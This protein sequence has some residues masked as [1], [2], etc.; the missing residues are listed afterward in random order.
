VTAELWKS[1]E[2]PAQLAL[3]LA[4]SPDRNWRR[5]MSP[6]LTYG[7]HDG[8]PRSDAR[9][10]AVAMVLCWDGLEWAMPLTVRS[11]ALVRHGGQVSL[12]GGL[13]DGDETPYAA[14][15]REL[16]EELGRRPAVQWI[17]VLEPLLVFASNTVVTSCVGVVGEW[18]QWQPNPHEVARVLKLEAASLLAA[19]A[20][21]PLEIR[22]GEL[23]FFAPQL[24]VE[25]HATWGATAVLLA[26][27]RGRLIRMGG[28]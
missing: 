23:R 6:Q 9:S 19:E 11:S 4:S 17:G 1:P 16:E 28:L 15:L 10:A 5:R 25:G 18:P 27:L 24:I 21:T 2:L 12:P 8:P 26:E 3:E 13:I 20:A 14:A 7:R 22:R